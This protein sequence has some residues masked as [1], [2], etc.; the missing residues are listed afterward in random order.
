MVS[1]HARRVVTLAGSTWPFDEA[2]AKLLELSRLRVSDDTIERVC[3]EEGQRAAAWMKSDEA[4]GEMMKKAS[5]ELE[6]STDG[7]KVNTTEGWAEMRLNVLAKRELAAAAEPGQWN[8]RVL[9]EPQARLARCAVAPCQKLGASW[10][11]MFK[12]ASGTK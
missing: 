2:S 9:P 4:P 6:F 3:Q 10:T 5:G 7:V 8:D 12:Q 11:R 1:E